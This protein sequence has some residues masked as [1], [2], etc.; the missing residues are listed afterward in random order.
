MFS[1]IKRN[2][3]AVKH[4]TPTCMIDFVVT[5]PYSLKKSNFYMYLY[6]YYSS[7]FTK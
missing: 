6:G 5:T 4:E 1:E 2:V 7:I 3:N